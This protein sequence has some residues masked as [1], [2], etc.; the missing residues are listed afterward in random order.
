MA[1]LFRIF[2]IAWPLLNVFI[3]ISYESLLSKVEYIIS[4]IDSMNNSNTKNYQFTEKNH[5]VQSFS[6]KD[7][8][9]EFRNHYCSCNLILSNHSKENRSKR[10]ES[11]EERNGCA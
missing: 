10:K 9:S 1:T 6:W 4:L 5:E 11:K 2:F 3:S 8:R 7:F